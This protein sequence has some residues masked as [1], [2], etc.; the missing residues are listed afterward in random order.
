MLASDNSESPNDYFSRVGT[1][2]RATAEARNR[3]KDEL[4]RVMNSREKV[5]KW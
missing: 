4:K 3:A 2:G 5:Q 1:T